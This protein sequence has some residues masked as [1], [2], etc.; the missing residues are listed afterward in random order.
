M[1]SGTSAHHP[2]Q[3]GHPHQDHAKAIDV[4]V[5][6]GELGGD[7]ET[8]GGGF[9]VARQRIGFADDRLDN[10]LARRVGGTSK[11]CLVEVDGTGKI[12]FSDASVAA[13]AIGRERTP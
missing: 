11:R 9:M 5:G 2:H 13:L 12:P 1:K 8:A 6:F 3:T 10:N 7:G 4:V